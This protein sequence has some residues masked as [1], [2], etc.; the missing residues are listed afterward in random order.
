MSDTPPADIVEQ[1]TAAISQLSLAVQQLS[2][3]AVPTASDPSATTVSAQGEVWEVVDPP[4]SSSS[5]VFPKRSAPS[6]SETSLV[7]ALPPAARSIALR[8][9]SGV[10]IGAVPRA[11]RAFQA[12]L[13]AKQ[14]IREGVAYR[15]LEPLIDIAVAHHVVLRSNRGDP[16]RVTS[17][18]DL[19]KLVVFDSNTLVESFPSL[20][21]VQLFCLGAET[22]VP[23]LVKCSV[24]RK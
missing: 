20:T 21:E 23:E 12:G 7:P 15:Q 10:S 18:A 8:N 11:E 6:Q 14:C 24:Q 22:S 13:R 9:L 2:Q 3:P 19:S 4:R 17:R 5:R 1:L 16:F